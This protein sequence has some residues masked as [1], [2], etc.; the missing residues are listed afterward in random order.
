MAIVKFNGIVTPLPETG[1]YAITFGVPSIKS[2]A[3]ID[4]ASIKNEI[5]AEGKVEPIECNASDSFSIIR[6]SG[7]T[8]SLTFQEFAAAD[9]K[10]GSTGQSTQGSAMGLTFQA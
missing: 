6:S 7:A 8:V 2:V 4:P 10:G 3:I 5:K 1:K 9:G